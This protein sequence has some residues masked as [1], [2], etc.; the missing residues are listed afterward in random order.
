MVSNFNL[1][2]RVL[3]LPIGGE[4]GT[5]TIPLIGGETAEMPSVY[6]TNKNDVVGCIIGKLNKLFVSFSEVFKRGISYMEL[7][8][9]VLIL[10][11]FR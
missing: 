4:K 6:N 1:L 2:L 3:A 5:D 9:L 11:D 7:N 8:L 10:M